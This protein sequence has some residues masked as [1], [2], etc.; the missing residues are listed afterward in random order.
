VLQ[1]AG[2]DQYN[3]TYSFRWSNTDMTYTGVI[4][5]SLKNGDVNGTGMPADKKRT[6]AFKGAA[7]GGVLTFTCYETTGGK[8]AQTGN[9]TLKVA[10]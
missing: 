2:A 8:P 6:F 10:G 4:A 5:G 7:K 9:G 3:A 1:P